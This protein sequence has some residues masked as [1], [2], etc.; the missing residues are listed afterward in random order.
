[1]PEEE[2]MHFC[3]QCGGPVQLLIPAGDDRPRHVCDRC[4]TIHYRNP[5]LVAGAIVEHDGRLLLCRRA[6]EPRYGTW[7]IPAGYMENGETIA[8]CA[9]R[10][11]SEE[12][13][14]VLAGLT[15][16]AVLDLPFI[17]QVYFV[18]RA[19]L[20][21][22]DVRP[23]AESLE[24]R[25]FDPAEIPWAELS[26]AVVRQVLRCYCDD[27]AGG[28]FPFRNLEVPRTEEAGEDWQCGG[29]PVGRNPD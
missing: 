11:A 8:G 3:T 1:M 16:Y 10:E 5:K 9:R 12:A 22:P 15:P 6:I 26:F 14:A 29:R 20:A 2:T 21:T 28:V 18:F 24:V 27:R 13:G 4:G 7:T 25:F 17:D 19:G 23:G